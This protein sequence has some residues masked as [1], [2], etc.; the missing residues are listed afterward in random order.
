M[1]KHTPTPWKERNGQ[2]I[3][4]NSIPLPV[5]IY[6]ARGYTAEEQ[7][8]RA[9]ILRACN[10]H[11]DLVTALERLGSVEAMERGGVLDKHRDAE[12]LARIDYA[13]AALAKSEI[14][15]TAP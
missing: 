5:I 12:L 6:H 8:V 2:L 11:A 3:D 15:P 7:E 4:A 14:L 10:A 13:R 1:S 9:F